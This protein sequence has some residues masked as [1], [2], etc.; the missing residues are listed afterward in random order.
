MKFL[1]AEHEV[2]IRK[3]I[4]QFATAALGHATHET[5]DDIRTAAADFGRD[6]L[7][8]GEGFLLGEIAH[9]TGVEEDDVGF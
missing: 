6:I 1:S 5:E 9:A 3:F 2:D 4:D 7:H 8:F